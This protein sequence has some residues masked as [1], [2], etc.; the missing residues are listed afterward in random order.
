MV[1]D[2]SKKPCL[3]LS[4]GKTRAS[5]HM[6]AELGTSGEVHITHSQPPRRN[7]FHTARGHVVGAGK[8]GN[9]G[10]A[11]HITVIHGQ[12]AQ[13]APQGSRPAIRIGSQR[14]LPYGRAVRARRRGAPAGGKHGRD[15]ADRWAGHW[16][17]R[18][19]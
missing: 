7:I 2:R 10:Q 14:W 13:Y 6:R 17:R 3:T 5:K 12:F 15:G 9:F 16:A 11:G 4:A 19:P 18:Q 8:A 1:L